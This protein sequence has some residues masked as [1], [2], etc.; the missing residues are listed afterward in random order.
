MRMIFGCAL[1]GILSILAG[2]IAMGH[3]EES[4]SHGLMP[5]VT[6]LATL[7]GGFSNWAF[8]HSGPREKPPEKNDK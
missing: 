1:L 8:S 3:V 5:L 6:A 7:A 4:T 2:V